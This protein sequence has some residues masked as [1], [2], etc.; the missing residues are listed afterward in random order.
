VIVGFEI[1]MAVQAE[2]GRCMGVT[3]VRVTARG[4]WVT[5]ILSMSEI[6]ARDQRSESTK[7]VEA[8]LVRVVTSRFGDTLG[9][10]KSSNRKPWRGPAI[11]RSNTMELVA[12]TKIRLYQPVLRL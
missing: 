7:V 3:L 2:T 8:F 5:R 12:R 4:V 11:G 9:E 6:M 10:D 1:V